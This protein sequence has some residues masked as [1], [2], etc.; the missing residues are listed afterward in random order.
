VAPKPPCKVGVST[1]VVIVT[2]A[3][4]SSFDV[5]ATGC[6]RIDVN[7]PMLASTISLT[8]SGTVAVPAGTQSGILIV[9]G[10]PYTEG[11]SKDS[12]AVGFRRPVGMQLDRTG[13]PTSAPANSAVKFRVVVAPGTKC[14][15][16]WT[17]PFNVPYPPIVKLYP[18]AQTDSLDATSVMVTLTMPAFPHPVP[19]Q[20][21]TEC[22]GEDGMAMADSLSIASTIPLLTGIDSIV[23][24]TVPTTAA[25]TFRVYAHGCPF[26]IGDGVRGTPGAWDGTL[27]FPDASPSGVARNFTD[28]TYIR[29][30]FE[31][32]NVTTFAFGLIGARSGDPFTFFVRNP[33]QPSVA[34]PMTIR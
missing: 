1:P 21:R 7:G 22:R 18:S 25:E 26:V 29:T 24:R 30:A 14:G 4:G 3:L 13:L 17:G 28:A 10:T 2:S 19:M 32:C 31:S 8:A 11:V 33:G 34:I 15:T 16:S 27:Y 20:F 6:D 23:P 9:K 12:V 5:T